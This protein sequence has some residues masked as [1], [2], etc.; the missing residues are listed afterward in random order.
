M[1]KYNYIFLIA[2]M[3]LATSCSIKKDNEIHHGQEVT[4]TAYSAETR[5]TKSTLIDGGTDVYWESGDNVKLFAMNTSSCLRTTIGSPNKI[6]S[7][8]GSFPIIIGSSEGQS[9]STTLW[10]VYP[11]RDDASFAADAITTVLPSEQTCRDGS[12]AQG[13]NI[14][15]ARANSFDLGFYNVCGGVRFRL[16]REGINKIIFS[17]NNDEA[18]AGKFKTTF[19][20]GVP[21]VS[22]VLTGESSIVLTM[23][24]GGTFKKD[25]WYYICA[26]PGTLSNG[27]TMRLETATKY[28]EFSSSSS[29]TI[30]RSVFGQIYGFDE[31]LIFT[32]KGEEPDEPG[33]VDLGLRVKWATCNLG[34]SQT[35][36]YGDYYQWAGKEDV[37]STSYFLNFEN[38]P[39]HVGI[40][41]NSGW[42][43]YIPIGFESYCYD[44]EKPDNKIVLDH[45]DDVVHDKLGGKWHMPEKRDFEEL[46]N[47]CDVIWT[48]LKGVYGRK[49]TSKK[50]GN[51]IFLPAAGYRTQDKFDAVGS[52]GSYWSSSLHTD[53]PDHAHLFFFNSDEVRMNQSYRFV[54]HSIRPIY[55]KSVTGV[56]LN[57]TNLKLF[58]GQTCSISATVLPSDASEQGVTWSSSDPN[59]ANVDQNGKVTSVSPGYVSI[60]ATTNDGGFTASCNVTVE[61]IGDIEQPIIEDL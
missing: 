21:V 58:T 48:T 10:A 22:E 11:Y 40:S 43:K 53:A 17:S 57:M 23:P 28:A 2:T 50:T 5:D 38:C 34:A 14:T 1:K 15:I 19:D 18:I 46:L 30:K 41:N 59:I 26:L 3:F 27:F 9:T 13:M 60:K 44:F 4:I 51:S 35:E 24:G 31:Y 7:F 16:T 32:P 33:V 61:D 8:S 56:S 25:V 39:Y 42:R 45:E 54:G 29:V 36:E 6:A 20:G 55:W 49:F 47:N 12:F 37:S 52:S